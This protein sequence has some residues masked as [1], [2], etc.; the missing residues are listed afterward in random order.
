MTVWGDG[1][2]L[3][4]AMLDG[5]LLAGAARLRGGTVRWA[6]L[7]LAALFGGTVA[8][9]SLFL[10]IPAA[11]RVLGFAA[12][13]AIAYGV[14]LEALRRAALFLGLSLAL[15]GIMEGLTEL[16]PCGAVLWRGGVLFLVTW[17]ALLASAALLYAACAALSGV[18]TE[19]KRR[20][21]RTQATVAGRTVSFRS[22]L[23]TGSFLR[24]P[25]TGRPVLLADS[26]VA[27]QLLDL[28][29]EA[30]RDPAAA[31]QALTAGR[32]ELQA[33]LIPFSAVGT[34]KGLLLGV[35]CQELLVGSRRC[36]GCILAFT[37]GDVSEDGSYHGL[38]GGSI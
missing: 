34:E 33:R 3:L 7:C 16:F 23:D 6:R 22:L 18:L 25:L 19:R 2:F 11:L 14:S 15:C 32:P 38:T 37:P 1:V 20:L 31:L 29:Q 4:N 26:S 10:P 24:D 5:L 28:R 13:S 21:L 17:R 35:R 8:F 36:P 9:V 27:G 30:L 12:I